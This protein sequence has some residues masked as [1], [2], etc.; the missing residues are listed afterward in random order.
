MHSG[1]SPLI[2]FVARNLLSLGVIAV[3]LVVGKSAFEEIRILQAA[4]NDR[5]TLARVDT[6]VNKSGKGDAAAAT[7]RADSYKGAPLHVLDA[8]IAELQ[9]TLA[10][11]QQASHPILTFPLPQGGEIAD[12]LATDFSRKMSIEVSRQELA[13][14]EQLRAFLIAGQSKEGARQRLEQLRAAHVEAYA[15]YEAHLQLNKQLSWV[16]RQLLNN[17]QIR[18]PR[19][20]ALEIVRGRLLEENAKAA[21]AFHRQQSAIDLLNSVK[22]S[23]VFAVDQARLEAV[24]APLRAHLAKADDLVAQNLVSRIWIPIAQVLPAAAFILALSFLAHLAIKAMFYFVLAP[25]ATKLKPIR[26]DRN[27]SGQIGTRDDDDA[28]RIASAVSQALRLDLDEQLLVLPDYVQSSPAASDNRTKWMLDWSRPWTCLIAGMV[29]LTAIRT[30]NGEPVV[31]SASEDPMSE[32]ALITLPAGSA[33]VFQPRCLVGVVYRV[34]TPLRISAHWRLGSMHAWLTLQLRY[35]IFHG[36]ATLI[37]KG[38]RGVRV[39]PAGQG[40]LISQSSSLGFSANVD[41]S[42]VRCET[43]YPFY[44]GKTA[45]LQ[46]RFEGSTGYYVYDETPRGG[47]RGNFFERGLEGLSDAVLKIFG[48]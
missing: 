7:V 42:T 40:R 36:P 47:K 27:D 11:P 46:D 9:R 2:R 25:L 19:L 23:D 17:T 30:K 20:S 33:M 8:R 43:F 28:L 35:L 4:R 1:L 45:L 26:L 41:Y 10:A 32:I 39:E 22:V 31:L 12:R 13:Y 24:A 44:Q 18:T 29:G 38:S 14:L 5:V 16:E 21:K 6:R 15:A 34:D 3:V 48:I 37:V